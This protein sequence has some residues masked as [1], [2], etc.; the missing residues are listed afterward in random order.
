MF[1]TV[2]KSH[3]EFKSINIFNRK[4]IHM[5]LVTNSYKD[6]GTKNNNQRILSRISS[7]FRNKKKNLHEDFGSIVTLASSIDRSV[8]LKGVGLKFE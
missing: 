3:L 6:G 1:T 2:H 7:H 4:M 8:S 5:C